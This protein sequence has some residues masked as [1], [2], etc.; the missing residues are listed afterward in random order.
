[1]DYR[2]Y[3][4]SRRE[5]A[6]YSA[7]ALGLTGILAF[8]FYN[9]AW[10]CLVFPLLLP[11]Y[12]RDQTGRLA[13]RRKKELKLQFKAAVQGMAAA[14][15]AGY[16]AENAL[17]EAGKDLKMMYSSHVPM[18]QELAAMQRK[19]DANQALEG[20]IA[21]FAERSGLEEAQTF[22]EI[23]ASAKRNG[24]DLTGIMKDTAR[25]ISET[26]ETERQISMV[27]ASRR[28]EQRI[29]N[30]IPFAMILYLRV[31][32]PGFLDPMYGNPAGI[33]IMTACLA[34]YAASW[35][36]GKRLLEIEV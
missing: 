13:E 17:R 28:Y 32:C 10:A 34:L 5:I 14:L 31:G 23:F 2:K 35:Y 7:E 21:D 36:L 30:K 4:L 19:L 3:R 25:T 18:V 29:M 20:V 11:L 8:C 16:S 26:V 15:S 24:G 9:S 12:L 22:S 33:L 6:L 1:M 27:L